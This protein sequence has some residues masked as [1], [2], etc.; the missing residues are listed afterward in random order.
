MVRG[1]MRWRASCFSFNPK[2]SSCRSNTRHPPRICKDSVIITTKFQT[3]C[4]DWRTP[5][6]YKISLWSNW[7]KWQHHQQP[8]V[9]RKER[10]LCVCGIIENSFITTSDA[11]TNTNVQQQQWAHS[12]NQLAHQ[13]NQH[14]EQITQHV[15]SLQYVLSRSDLLPSYDN[16]STPA[17][18]GV[19]MT[20]MLP[21]SSSP[22][23]SS[24]S[25]SSLSSST[26]SSPN[27]ELA[28]AELR[29]TDPT[30]KSCDAITSPPTTTHDKSHTASTSR[31]MMLTLNPATTRKRSRSFV[32]PGWSVPPRVL[33]VD[34]DSIFRR[35][36]TRLLEMAGCTIEVAVDGVE[37]IDKLGTD[38]YDIVLMV[39][40]ILGW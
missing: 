23:I 21:P 15:G 37:A 39:N 6:H 19:T 3:P 5:W 13:T 38:H 1:R 30:F 7:C 2:S 10:V 25:T 14:V 12:Y 31:Q 20:T 24:S 22:S 35:L 17:Q 28:V 26:Q 16:H 40:T 29:V 8:K 36:S 27:T 11:R 18:A 34:D 33:L 9:R 4:L 32:P